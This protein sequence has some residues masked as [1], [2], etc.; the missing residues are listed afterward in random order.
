[1]LDIIK[2][3]SQTSLPEIL[4]FA[5]VIFIFLAIGGK[6]G[7]QI[8]TDN[9]PKPMAAGIGV[10]LLLTSLALFVISIIIQSNNAKTTEETERKTRTDNIVSVATYKLRPSLPLNQP[11]SQVMDLEWSFSPNTSTKCSSVIHT[12]D[13]ITILGYG[14]NDEPTVAKRKTVLNITIVSCNTAQETKPQITTT[15]GELEGKE[16]LAHRTKEGIWTLDEPPG[17]TEKQRKAMRNAGF[18]DPFSGLPNEKVPIGKVI[19]FKDEN[20]SLILG[21]VF[22]G[23]KEGA[24]GM[25]FERVIKDREPYAQLS[26]SLD[27]RTTILDDNDNEQLITMTLNG[28]GQLSLS[29]NTKINSTT[30]L[31]GIIA[32]ST[33]AMPGVTFTGPATLK[34]VIQEL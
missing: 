24:V 16:L 14:E 15:H 19:T 30:T 13:V 33:P 23:R 18:M 1:M 2:A 34:M 6:F 7:A 28:G 11:I 4:A 5:G 17:T 9:I 29:E 20:V 26:Y 22:P 31:T 27:I 8:V 21:T 25:K 32:F 3:L 12:E 10:V